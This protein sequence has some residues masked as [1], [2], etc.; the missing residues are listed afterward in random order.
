[1]CSPAL[2]FY[3]LNLSV[4]VPN[5]TC[6]SYMKEEVGDSLK[7]L[8]ITAVVTGCIMFLIW[9]CQYALWRKYDKEE[10]FDSRN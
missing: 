10:G 9:I 3:S 4:G 6:L 1:M 7:Y 5:K 2:F 8:G